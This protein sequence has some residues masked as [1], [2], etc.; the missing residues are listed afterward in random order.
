MTSV[1]HDP[2]EII[3]AHMVICCSRK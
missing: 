2:L 1:S 3:Y